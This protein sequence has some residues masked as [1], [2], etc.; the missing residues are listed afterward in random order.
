MHNFLKT[1]YDTPISL[2]TI[3][4]LTYSILKLP[5]RKSVATTY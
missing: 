4:V 2:E 5:F 1:F 3:S